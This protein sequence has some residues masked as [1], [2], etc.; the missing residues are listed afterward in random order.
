M[1]LAIIL[2]AL[3]VAGCATSETVYLRN[4]ARQ[5]VQCGPYDAGLNDTNARIIAESQLRNCVSDYQRQGYERVP[6]P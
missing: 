2:C 6:G 1:R 4:M 5:A 3:I